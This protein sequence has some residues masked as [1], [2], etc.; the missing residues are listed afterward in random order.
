ML[1]GD[2]VT[3]VLSQKYPAASQAGPQ[4]YFLKKRSEN[5]SQAHSESAEKFSPEVTELTLNTFNVQ[6]DQDTKIN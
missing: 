6:C 5:A 1:S 4:A 3:I 2:L